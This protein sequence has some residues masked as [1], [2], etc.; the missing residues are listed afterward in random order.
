MP[1]QRVHIAIMRKS[2]GL[3]PK[4]LAGEKSIE[5]RWYLQKS[6]PWDRIEAGDIIYFKNSGE[7]VTLQAVVDKVKQFDSLTPAKVRR[8]LAEY[9]QKDG[10]DVG[11]LDQYYKMF[12]DKK[13]C[14][15]IFLRDVCQVEPFEIDKKGF[16]T[17]SAWLTLDDIESVRK[18]KAPLYKQIS[19]LKRKN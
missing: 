1:S 9:G 18:I 19:L 7:P 2:W 12:R 14:L 3:L 6:E 13:Y 10:L 4:I 17:M 16:G 11:E 8:I 15:L 5:S